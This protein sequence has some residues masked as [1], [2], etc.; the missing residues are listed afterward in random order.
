MG[1]MR[2]S[3][4]RRPRASRTRT[5]GKFTSREEVGASTR[6]IVGLVHRPYSAPPSADRRRILLR[7]GEERVA[8]ERLANL[9]RGRRLVL[10]RDGLL[11]S[12][13][14]PA[15]LLQALATSVE[16]EWHAE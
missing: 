2:D 7:A 6:W 1:P 14:D 15:R 10:Q 5:T 13:I 9:F 4:S 16:G 3:T 12:F 11:G 8:Q